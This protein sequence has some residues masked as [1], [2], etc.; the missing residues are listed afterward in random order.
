MRKI[1]F[2]LYF[3]FMAIVCNAQQKTYKIQSPDK[4]ITVVFNLS[5]ATY[6]IHY[7]NQPLLNTS[8][9]GLIR[10]DDDFSKNLKVNSVSKPQVIYDNYEM[11]NAKKKKITY[12]AVQQI[13]ATKNASGKQMNII[14]KVSNDGVAF[15]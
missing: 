3:A 11:L 9:M 15:C 1:I 12:A 14:F 4:Q 7:K 2:I 8:R 5:E 13:F 10:K 6:A